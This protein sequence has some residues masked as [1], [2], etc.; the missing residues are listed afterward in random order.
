MRQTESAPLVDTLTTFLE[1]QLARVSGKAEMTGVIRY[2]LGH[3][4]GLVRFLDDGCIE[5]DTNIVERLM[6]PA[7]AHPQNAL[8]AGHDDGA[9]N[10]A[11]IASLIETAKLNGIDPQTW[12]ADVLTCLVN[13]WPND[14]LDELIPWVWAVLNRQAKL[15]A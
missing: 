3:W 12:L 15:A 8:F 10:W 2:A 11:M 14:R 5:L 9:E 1:H 13:L 6:R 7:G 4:G